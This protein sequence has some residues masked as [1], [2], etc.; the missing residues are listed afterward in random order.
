MNESTPLQ[1]LK[2]LLKSKS[3][4]V[5]IA[6]G[7]RGV[8]SLAIYKLVSINFGVSGLGLFSHFQ[9][10]TSLFTQVSDQGTTLG[11]MSLHKEEQ[12]R[13]RL[14]FHAF[15]LNTVFFLLIS[16][17]VYIKQDVFLR[18]FE[19]LSFSELN[20][21]LAG[22][23]IFIL[24]YN[25]LTFSFIYATRSFKL[26]LFLTIINIIVVF[27]FVWVS[28]QWGLTSTMYGFVFGWGLCSLINFSVAYFTQV[29]PKL[30]FSFSMDIVKSLGN[31]ILIAGAGLL[32]GKFVDYFVRDFAF[33]WYGI[34]NTGYWQ[35]QVRLSDSYR[36]AFLGTLG[37]V[38]YSGISMQITNTIFLKEYTRK[39][40][41]YSVVIVLPALVGIYIFRNH[42]FILLYSR[43]LLP[44]TDFLY[45]QLIADLFALPSF[46]LVYVLIAR[47]NFKVYLKVHLVSALVYVVFILVF[48]LLSS[49]IWVIPAA[50]ALRYFLFF[51][52]LFRLVK[53]DLK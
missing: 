9:N 26:L 48:S 2:A 35:S 43:E 34:E 6:V 14:F 52:L 39:M 11:I 53:K 24:L 23:S 29:M 47:K 7:L 18:Y 36:S 41:M 22:L 5:V 49:E 4:L 3:P 33:D 50:N 1:Q 17:I 45:W 10:F 30:E 8:L 28:S 27:L 42:L 44:A 38:F 32:L 31:F 19:G 12:N 40:M 37:L 25:S 46:L 15:I 20:F 13:P 16:L 21:A 51:F